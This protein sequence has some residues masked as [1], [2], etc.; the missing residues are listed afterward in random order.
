VVGPLRT[1]CVCTVQAFGLWPGGSVQWR[2][3]IRGC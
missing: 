3:R 2:E 1:A